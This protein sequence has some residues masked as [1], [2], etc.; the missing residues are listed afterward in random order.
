MKKLTNIQKEQKRVTKMCQ[1]TWEMQAASQV[2]SFE[3]DVHRWY[4]QHRPKCNSVHLPLFWTAIWHMVHNYPDNIVSNLAEYISEIYDSLDKDIPYHTIT[5]EVHC[6]KQSF[7]KLPSNVYVYSPSVSY[8]EEQGRMFSLI[9][10]PPIFGKFYFNYKHDIFCSYFLSGEYSCRKRLND[11][12]CGYDGRGHDGFFVSSPVP[13]PI[14]SEILSRSTFALTPRGTQPYN[15]RLYEAM[16]YG[17][18]PVYISDRYSLPYSDEVDWHNLAVLVDIDDIEKL[19]EILRSISPEQI[20]QM[21]EYGQWFMENYVRVDKICERIFM[22]ADNLE[23]RIFLETGNKPSKKN[24]EN[25]F[26]Q[27]FEEIKRQKGNDTTFEFSNMF[28]ILTDKNDQAGTMKGHYFHQDLYVAQLIFSAKPEKHLDIGSRTDGFIAHVASFREIEL[29]DIRPLESHLENITFRQADLMELPPELV[30]YCDSISSLHAIEH[31]GLG[32]YGDPVD[33]YGH[34]KAIK[35][36]ANILKKDGFFY[37]SVPIGQQR[38]EF[39]AHRVFSVGYLMKILSQDFEIKSFS[40]VNDEGDFFENVELTEKN[41][42]LNYNCYYGC[43]IFILQK[44]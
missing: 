36:I 19:P 11:F 10:S 33:Y 9:P 38:I 7:P 28:P 27:D 44:R 12:L 31:F 25:W 29:I 34:L 6:N 4:L 37:F 39:N 41:V 21:Q 43:G 23:N 3:R 30:D 22:H 5:S 16:Q 35:N 18:I 26:Y 42:S 2:M 15:H 32:R 20:R 24:E 1:F 40:Y 14:C 8:E 13:Y 17:A